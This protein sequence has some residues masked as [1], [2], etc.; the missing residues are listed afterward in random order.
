MLKGTKSNVNIEL[1][2]TKSSVKREQVRNKKG[3]SRIERGTKSDTV[4]SRLIEYCTT[5]KSM[6][7]IAEFLG[8]KN[9][10]KLKQNYINPLLG[11]SLNMTIPDKPKSRLQ[12]YVTIGG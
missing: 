11:K 12:K 9:R 2:G 3:L 6:Q 4:M 10:T 8:Y 1:K 5:P 7:E